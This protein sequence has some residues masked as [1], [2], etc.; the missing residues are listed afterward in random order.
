MYVTNCIYHTFIMII[1]PSAAY[2]FWAYLKLS[3]QS[4]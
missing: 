2:Y 4:L 1:I 3:K